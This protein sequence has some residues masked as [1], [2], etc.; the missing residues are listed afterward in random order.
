M[1]EVLSG[2]TL[3]ERHTCTKNAKREARPIPSLKTLTPQQWRHFCV[4][5]RLARFSEI[6]KS[7]RASLDRPDESSAL[8]EEEN[9]AGEHIARALQQLHPRQAHILKP[10][11]GIGQPEHTLQEV[12]DLLG[13]TRERIRQ[14]QVKAETKLKRI[15]QE[16]D[17]IGGCGEE[18][19][20]AKKE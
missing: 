18:A 20:D 11:Y 16:M 13:L 19:D 10:R 2:N 12:A 3:E 17:S 5:R 9:P 4:A 14:I 15:F 1:P 6:D 8:V 7:E